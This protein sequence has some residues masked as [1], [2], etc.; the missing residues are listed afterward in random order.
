MQ[1]DLFSG[2]VPF[3][4]T[5]RSSYISAPTA[6]LARLKRNFFMSH[7][8][9]AHPI[10]QRVIR[11][12]AL[13]RHPGYHF[14]GN[15]LGLAFTEVRDAHSILEL[16]PDT[17]CQ[18]VDGQTN[19][20]AVAM[21]ADMGLATGIRANLDGATRLATVALSLQLTGVPRLGP[22][23]ASSVSQGFIQDSS[24]KQGLS[25][26]TVTA[27][28]ELLCFGTGA[29]MVLRPPTHMTLSP[30]PWVENPP[31]DH[32]E[33]DLDSLS[34]DEQ[35]ILSHARRSL[36]ASLEK[37]DDFIR[38]F[39]GFHPH[40][41]ERGAHA[42]LQNGPHV[43]NRVGHVQGGIT[44]GLALTTANA[45]L[46]Q[47]WMLSS[48]TASYVSPGEGETITARSH[49]IHRGKL[50]AVVRTEVTSSHGRQV[51]EVLTN[52][53]RRGATSIHQ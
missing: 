25:T 40:P 34:E 8:L 39:F 11:A 6:F 30:I 2:G 9:D 51:L 19:I 26:S 27:G 47:D 44:L 33:L 5:S 32:V 46:G 48:V 22:L 50:T 38:H 14:G 49:T 24:G 4:L 42:V 41:I 3:A 16:S 1:D 43:G 18:D 29:F 12:I 10:I 35:W 37:G 36:S 17:H 45:A 28:G 53:A 52:H 23:K 31:P 20:A 7:E 21:L 13:N 15:F